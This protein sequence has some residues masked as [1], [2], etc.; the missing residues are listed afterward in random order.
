[1][2]SRHNISKFDNFGSVILCKHASTNDQFMILVYRVL[3]PGGHSETC[4][5]AERLE[6][7]F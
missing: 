6:V 1:M 4:K 2:C 7:S 5:Q 3:F